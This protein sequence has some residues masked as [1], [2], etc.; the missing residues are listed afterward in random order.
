MLRALYG[1]VDENEE[2][3]IEALRYDLRK[4][5]WEARNTELDPMYVFHPPR[6]ALS[7]CASLRS[8]CP[9]L[10][11]AGQ[12]DT[13]PGRARPGCLCRAFDERLH[14]V[15]ECGADLRARGGHFAPLCS[16]TQPGQIR[17]LTRS[18]GDCMTGKARLC[19][20]WRTLAS[21]AGSG[22]SP[23]RS[24]LCWTACRCTQSPR[25]RL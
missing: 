10:A 1:L 14:E 20:I 22:G 15:R 2:M 3:L 25:A 17:L 23:R 6:L 21:G 16:Q 24:L 8:F 19:T 7:G 9:A 18:H 4:P 13:A 5:V 12:R 11:V